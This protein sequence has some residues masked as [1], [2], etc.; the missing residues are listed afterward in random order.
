MAA[1]VLVAGGLVAWRATASAGHRPGTATAGSGRASLVITAAGCPQTWQVPRSG[2]TTFEIAN[3]S[4]QVTDIGLLGSNQ[5]TLYAEIP[6]LAPGVARP[7]TVSLEPGRYMWRCIPTSGALSYSNPGLVRGG[8]IADPSQG[9]TPVLPDDLASATYTYRKSIT[10]G[11]NLL[12]A[13]TDRLQAAVDAGNLAAAKRLWL[14]AHLDYARLGAA[15]D[16]FG[17]FNGEIDGRADGLAGGVSSPQFTGFLRLE[18]ALWH[19][20][21]LATVKAVTHQLDGFVHGLVKAFPH[22][23][24]PAT[25]VPLRA[26]EILENTLQFELT[27]DTDE[28][29]HTNLATAWANAQG[30]ETVLAA[31]TPLLSTRNPSLLAEAKKGVAGLAALLVTYRRPDGWWTPV[32]AL[33]TT[34]REKLDS[35]IDGLLQVLDQIPPNLEAFDPGAD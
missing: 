25:D 17:P 23:L 30:T 29:S 26:H 24:M 8:R 4:K 11:L 28:G 7:V 14:A 18:Y 6:A 5:S 34:A 32:Q 16:T 1:L 27:A 9:Y 10:A 2:T 31:L 3:D 12:A 21:P 19:D 13:A 15:Y 33:T 20:Q 35:T 22:Q